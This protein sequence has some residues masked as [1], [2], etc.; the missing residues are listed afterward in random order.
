MLQAGYGFS[1]HFSLSVFEVVWVERGRQDDRDQI[2]CSLKSA[3]LF[4]RVL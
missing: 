3:T 2:L 1:F 4:R